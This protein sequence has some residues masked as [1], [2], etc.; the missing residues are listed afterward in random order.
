MISLAIPL[1]K[2]GT[3]SWPANR[4]DGN[5]AGTQLAIG[6]MLRLPARLNLDAMKLSPTARTIARAAQEYGI[7]V[8]D[9]SGSVAFSAENPIALAT[10]RY[11]TI[12]RG[13]W[14]FR[15]MLG[16]KSRREVAFP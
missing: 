13:R 7:I 12:F 9:T 11:D 5:K 6:Q 8:T 14:A 16:D 1:T 4:T 15:E 3:E 10:N 2:K